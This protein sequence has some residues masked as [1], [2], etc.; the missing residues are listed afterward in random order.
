MKSALTGDVL[1]IFLEGMLDVNTV[2]SISNEMENLVKENSDKEIIVDCSNLSYISSMGLRLMLKM[3]KLHK[4]KGFTLIEVSREVYEVFESSGFTKIINIKKAL[5]QI[6]VDGLVMLGSGMSGKVYR[7]DDEKT[8]KVY[9]KNWTLAGV[10]KEQQTAQSAFILGLDTAISYDVVRVGESYGIIYE[11]LQAETFDKFI[12]AHADQTEEYAKIFA[13]F[14]KKQHSIHIDDES[15][16]DYRQT[17][18]NYAKKVELYNEEERK[19]AVDLFKKVPEKNY[20]VHGDLNL[21]NVM[22]QDGQLFMIDMGEA[23]KGHPLFDL[24]WIYYVYVM[25]PTYVPSNISPRELPKIL[26][27]TFAQEYF[28]TKDEKTLVHYEKVLLPYAV[29]QLLNWTLFVKVQAFFTKAYE[30]FLPEVMKNNIEP[31]DF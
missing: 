8:L 24:A 26:W 28:N 15:Y 20:F 7:L 3:R 10:Q 9:N 14:V 4:S 2:N 11:L 12:L 30:E 5:Q 23:S 21:G 27:R 19:F 22:I 1:T 29:I 25:K 13:K 17:M 6:S 31:L 16:R 18:I